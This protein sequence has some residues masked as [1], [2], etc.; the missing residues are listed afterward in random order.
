MEDDGEKID[1]VIDAGRALPDVIADT[2]TDFVDREVYKPGERLPNESELARRMGVARSSVRTALQRL[3]ARK[4]LEVRRGL[5]W[6]VRKRRQVDR[7]TLSGM[8]AEHHYRLSDLFELRIGLEDLAVS[9]A[10]VR[11][12]P[13]EIDTITELNLAHELA[14]DD[15]DEMQRTDEAMHEAIVRAGHNDLL[16]TNYLDVV[17]EL[18][19]WRRQTYA[20]PG[21][22][23]RSAREHTR[24]IRY[25]GN[26]DPDGARG[27]MHSHLLRVYDEIADIVETPLDLGS[28]RPDVQPPWRPR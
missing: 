28:A 5:G 19:E 7:V 25:L 23:R 16:V 10:A 1:L 2:L 22:A 6:Y 17:A 13:S 4:V 21:V 15:R 14:G 26:G 12:T 18:S 11:A 20:S 9:L 3:E 27:A 8:L 24:V